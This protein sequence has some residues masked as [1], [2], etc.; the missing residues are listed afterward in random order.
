VR[1]A[2]VLA[3]FAVVFAGAAVWRVRRDRGRITPASKTWLLVAA[4]FALVCAWLQLR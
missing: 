2:A 1:A 4:I 3:F